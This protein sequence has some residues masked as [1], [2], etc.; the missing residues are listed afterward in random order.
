MTQLHFNP[1][2]LSHVSNFLSNHHL[3]VI[4]TCGTKK[5]PECAVVGYS[6]DGQLELVIATYQH[7]KKVA[8]MGKKAKVALAIGSDKGATMQYEGIATQVKQKDLAHMAERHYA[9]VPTAAKYVNTDSQILYRIQPCWIRL[10]EYRQD[11]WTMSEVG[12]RGEYQV[13]R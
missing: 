10:T 3:A 8:N 6:L 1:Q 13:M 5:S 4:A 12:V 11:P 2:T 9:L 7:T